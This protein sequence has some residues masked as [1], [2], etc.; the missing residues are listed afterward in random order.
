M[1]SNGEVIIDSRK[2]GAT[3]LAMV[4]AAGLLAPG[5]LSSAAA[6]S[7]TYVVVEAKSS[8][9]IHVGKSGLFS[10]AG[11]KHE[12]EAPVSGTVTADPANLTASRVDLNFAT[13]RLTVR[14]E[15]EPKGDA[16]KV[17]EKMH[18]ADVLD[19]VRFPEIRFTSTRVTGKTVAGGGYE[20]RIV[21][22]LNLRGVV[23]DISLPVSVKL[24]GSL[25]TATGTI[26]LRHDQFGMKPVSVAGVV[27]VAQEIPIDFEI[28][29]ERQ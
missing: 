21:G 6:S 15:G 18:S 14:E 23:V 16:A 1:W 4:C 2:T 28:V 10:F 13:A 29:A 9:R 17:Q 27:K 22:D 7:A 8:F 3:A 25:L 11:H 20:L 5:L 24:T 19:A 12:V 26:K